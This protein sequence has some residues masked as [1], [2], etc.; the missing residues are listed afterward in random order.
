[1]PTI[2]R[3]HI[4]NFMSFAEETIDFAPGL[5]LVAGANR[6]GKTNVLRALR[7]VL[8]NDGPSYSD[9]NADDVLR[10]GHGDSKAPSASV[11]V[12]YEDGSWVERRRSRDE[13]LYVLHYADGR[14]EE[15][16]GIGQGFYDPVAEIT[17]F[18]P[19][20]TGSKEK[21]LLGWQGVTDPKLLVG[22]SAAIVDRQ[23]TRMVGTQPLEEAVSLAHSD[24]SDQR[25]RLKAAEKQAADLEQRLEKLAGLDEAEALCSNALGL[26]EEAGTLQAQVETGTSIIGR[27]RPTSS[28][29]GVLD[30]GL[31]PVEAA[32]TTA[33]HM[34]ED[35]MGVDNTLLLA[36]TLVQAIGAREQRAARSQQLIPVAEQAATRAVALLGEAATI[37]QTT[38]LVGSVV[39]SLQATGTKLQTTTQQVSAATAEEEALRAQVAEELERNPA[40]PHCGRLGQC[41]HCGQRTEALV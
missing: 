25:K 7:W 39:Q 24:L 1:M 12:E 27:L 6:Q 14:E 35:A 8:L 40:C 9:T 13:N 15:H 23:L 18:A 10:H 17:G 20:A 4:N 11:M 37:E 36:S 32:A 30:V 26:E 21:V 22:E 2:A 28:R 31:P 16:S 41:P 33:R 29:L 5:N 19:V 38:G 3:L 34:L